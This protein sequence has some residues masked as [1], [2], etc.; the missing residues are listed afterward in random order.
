MQKLTVLF[1]ILAL[2]LAACTSAAGPAAEAPAQPT[3]PPTALPDTAAS[4]PQAPQ[5]TAAPGAANETLPPAPSEAAEPV[6]ANA[7]A[8]DTT[9]TSGAVT[10]R[11]VPAESTVTYEVS[12]TFIRD[13]NVIAIAIGATAGVNGEIQLDPA[14]P[15]NAT[16]GPLTVDISTFKSDSSRRDG[17]IRDR[18]LE[19][20]K[21]PLV[22]FTPTSIEGLPAAAE[23]GVEY[24][25]TIQGDLTIRETTRPA[26]FQAVVSLAD[27]TLTGLASTTFLMSDFGFGPISIMGVL[28]TE[29]L[30]K[31]TVAFVAR[32]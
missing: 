31:I 22:T 16:L 3:T 8:P 7:A 15:Q 24:P 26:T 10:Y 21:Y 13:G 11:L 1:L 27:N 2:S 25:L 14:Q 30:V 6:P 20:A 5:A 12:E 9:P 32:P 29:D 23:P 18:F 19:S 4:A 28:N 17:A